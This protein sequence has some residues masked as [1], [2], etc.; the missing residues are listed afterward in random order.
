MTKREQ[1]NLSFS[2]A[3]IDGIVFYFCNATQTGSPQT[4]ATIL[5]GYDKFYAEDLIEAIDSAQAG[6]YYVDYHH[7]DSLTD[8]FG[9]T[10]VPPNVVVSSH[11]YQIPL[12]VWKELMQEWLNF[13]KS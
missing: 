11:N 13:L 12:Q 5:E 4:F 1:F 9:I 8:D 3:I 7:P 10:I 6:Q 2:K